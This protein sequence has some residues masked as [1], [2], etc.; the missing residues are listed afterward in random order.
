MKGEVLSRLGPGFSLEQWDKKCLGALHCWW[1]MT[2]FPWPLNRLV[3]PRPKRMP[4]PKRVPKRY[5][6]RPKPSADE[7]VT[8]RDDDSIPDE[9]ITVRDDE[10]VLNDPGTAEDN[11]TQEAPDSQPMIGDPQTPDLVTYAVM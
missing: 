8:V 5:P 2:E 1:D 11:A 7:T 6:L 9:A 3:M 4:K 10:S